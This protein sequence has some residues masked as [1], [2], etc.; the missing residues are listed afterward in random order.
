[1]N[2]QLSLDN[3]ECTQAWLRILAAKARTKKSN[4]L[5]SAEGEDQITDLLLATAGCEAIIKL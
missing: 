5:K 2:E 1:M 4:D 3:Y